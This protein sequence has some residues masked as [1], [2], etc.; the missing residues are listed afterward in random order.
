MDLFD[1]ASSA[2]HRGVETSVDAA[3]AMSTSAPALRDKVFRAV[4]AAG[5]RGLTVLEMCQRHG[6]DRMGVQPRFSELRSMRK[7]A[8]SGLRRKNPSGVRAI[9]WTLPE[10][11]R[12]P[13]A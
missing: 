4:A 8:D 13:G 10:H 7:I 2:G 9:C 11:V 1:Y 12:E 6:L 5:E 3:R